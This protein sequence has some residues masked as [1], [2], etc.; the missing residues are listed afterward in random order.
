MNSPSKTFI[1][2]RTNKSIFQQSF[3][4]NLIFANLN[5]FNVETKTPYTV[6]KK[7]NKIVSN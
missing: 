5:F 7:L 4:Y 2:N 3:S 1:G 6:Y